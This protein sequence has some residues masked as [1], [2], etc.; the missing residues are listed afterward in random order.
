[1]NCPTIHTGI[2]PRQCRA[3]HIPSSYDLPFYKDNLSPTTSVH[4]L[5]GSFFV[6]CQFRWT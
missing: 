5:E 2:T 6:D 3:S 1:V 4:P